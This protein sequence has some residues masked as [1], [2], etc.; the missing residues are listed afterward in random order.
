M[1]KNRPPRPPARPAPPAPARKKGLV[2][3]AAGALVVLVI[4]AAW[5]VVARRGGA[6]GTL[7]PLPAR[8]ATAAVAF[9]DFVGSQTCGE[10]HAQQFAAWQ[11]ST[12]GHAG[13]EPSRERVIAPFNGIPLQS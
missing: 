12:H 2:M 3:I 13:G 9:E 1:K 4:A 11:G 6:S 5:F 10:C 8:A 7:P